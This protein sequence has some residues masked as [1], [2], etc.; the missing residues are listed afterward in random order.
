MFRVLFQSGMFCGEHRNLDKAIAEAARLSGSVD[1][2]GVRVEA[3]E[4][5][6]EDYDT[7]EIDRLDGSGGALVRW[8]SGVTSY[9][10]TASIN[11]II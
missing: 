1:Y 9:T 6:S 2:E 10:T 5:G 7:G 8:D 4:A 11:A 3:G